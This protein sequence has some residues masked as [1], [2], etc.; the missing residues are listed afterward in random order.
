[1][2]GKYIT[3]CSDLKKKKSAAPWGQEPGRSQSRSLAGVGLAGLGKCQ[4]QP[5]TLNVSGKAAL[6]DEVR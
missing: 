2:K 3:I 1:M 5:S 6:P 4:C